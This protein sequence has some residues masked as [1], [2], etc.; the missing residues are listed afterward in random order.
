MVSLATSRAELGRT[1]GRSL[2]NAVELGSAA[3]RRQERTVFRDEIARMKPSLDGV[4]E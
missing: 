2:G 4:R 1:L 3:E